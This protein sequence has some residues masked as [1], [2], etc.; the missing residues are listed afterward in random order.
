MDRLNAII[1]IAG[2][3]LAILNIYALQ[4]YSQ[5]DDRL[6]RLAG[7]SI[8][9]TIAL[10]GCSKRHWGVITVFILLILSD[11]ALLYYE[12]EIAKIFQFSLRGVSYILIGLQATRAFKH[13]KLGT[14]QKVLFA[15]IFAFNF[16]LLYTVSEIFATEVGNPILDLL[17]YFQGGSAI[18]ILFMA[19]LYLNWKGNRLSIIYFLGALGFMLSDLAAFAAYHLNYKDFFIVD[20]TFYVLA[21]SSFLK[22]YFDRSKNTDSV[23]PRLSN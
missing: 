9:F 3:S 22:F 16:Y 8:F 15:T 6:I 23:E 4:E 20:R 2:V 17:F 14:T 12:Q 7:T 18:F 10:F 1:L 13:S 5:L 11:I 19:A 21:L